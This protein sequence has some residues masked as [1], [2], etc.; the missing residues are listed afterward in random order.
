MT[1]DGGAFWRAQAAS[2][3]VTLFALPFV[4]L[5]TLLALINPFWFRDQMFNWVEIKVNQF[6][7]WRNRKVYA[8]Y[9]GT[10]PELWHALKDPQN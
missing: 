3:A 9:L 4:L 7:R 5:A 6:A 8:I 2:L 1:R 10:D